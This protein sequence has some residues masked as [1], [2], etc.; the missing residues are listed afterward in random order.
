M[1]LAGIE[2]QHPSVNVLMEVQCHLAAVS[3][4]DASVYL[5]PGMGIHLTVKQLQ[6]V[7]DSVRLS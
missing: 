3:G 5:I 4:T 2:Q 7:L 6:T 1:I